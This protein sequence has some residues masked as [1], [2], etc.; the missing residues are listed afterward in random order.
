MIAHTGPDY[1]TSEL[2]HDLV[3]TEFGGHQHKVQLIKNL[4]YTVFYKNK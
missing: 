1:Q 4:K 3:P 2:G